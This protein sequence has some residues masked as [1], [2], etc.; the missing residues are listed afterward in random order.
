MK[1]IGQMML[2]QKLSDYYPIVSTDP[3][4]NRTI[5]TLPDVIEKENLQEWGLLGSGKGAQSSFKDQV[6]NEIYSA[7]K[8]S[9]EGDSNMAEQGR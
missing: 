5:T 4:T 9:T 1:V 7:L 6:E 2:Q 3:F 8:L